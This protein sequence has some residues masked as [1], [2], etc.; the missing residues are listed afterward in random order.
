MD[1]ILIQKFYLLFDLW[2]KHSLTTKIGL[3]KFIKFEQKNSLLNLK[4]YSKKFIQSISKW[5]FE[6]LPKLYFFFG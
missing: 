2:D 4:G 6:C 1:L 5:L 3:K